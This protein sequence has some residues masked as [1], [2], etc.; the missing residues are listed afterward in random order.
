LPKNLIKL[1]EKIKG[2]CVSSPCP[3]KQKAQVTNKYKNLRAS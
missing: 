1:G 2:S 3:A